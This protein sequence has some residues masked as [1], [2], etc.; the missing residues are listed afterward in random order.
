[1]KVNYAETSSWTSKGVVRLWTY[2]LYCN[3]QEFFAI[4]LEEDKFN[5][6]VSELHF[7]GEELL[8]MMTRFNRCL[9]RFICKFYEVMFRLQLW[10]YQD[11]RMDLIWL[12]PRKGHSWLYNNIEEGDYLAC[13]LVA[14][15]I[16]FVK[17]TTNKAVKSL[18]PYSIRMLKCL[19]WLPKLNMMMDCITNYLFGAPRTRLMKSLFQK[20]GKNVEWS[21]TR[22]ILFL[23][24]KYFPIFISRNQRPRML[25]LKR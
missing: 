22:V 4:N 16:F 3:L 5:T 11:S 7:L 8:L 25:G 2:S 13:T 18:F 23:L 6:I 24:S 17:I 20:E 1:M 9:D 14:E 12:A 19:Y 15:S 10:A 21:S